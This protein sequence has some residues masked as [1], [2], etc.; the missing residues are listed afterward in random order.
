MLT[1]DQKIQ[2]NIPSKDY[3]AY[4]QTRYKFMLD[5]PFNISNRCCN[6][7]KK[8]PAKSS[9]KK[10][11]TAQMA[12]ES[13]LRTQKWLENG[14]NA[15]DNAKPISNPMSFWVDDDVLLYVKEYN[16]PLAS[17]YGEI[18][19]EDELNG[20]LNMA[21]LGLFDI[22][23]EPLYTTGVNRSGCTYCGFGLHLEKRPNRLEMIE[24]VS[25]PALLDYC[26]RGGA[27]DE[28]G[29]WKPA[30]GG[31]GFWFVYKWINIHGGFNIHIPYYEKY[32][33][34]YG[35]ELTHKYLY[36]ELDKT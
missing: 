35:N 34:K 9:L 19:T 21:D 28:D 15:F 20:Q 17:I 25:N 12:S 22:G 2:A 3:S 23:R 36:D 18:K 33:K 26:I 32:E 24:K 8:L 7:M 11:I 5:A 16:L 10:M 30:N 6:V 13:R 14:C 4:A 29:L 27:F 1:K 31:L